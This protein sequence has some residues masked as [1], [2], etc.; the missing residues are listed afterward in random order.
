MYSFIT[1][2]TTVDEKEDGSVFAIQGPQGS[3]EVYEYE[4]LMVQIVRF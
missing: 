2:I 4:H 3:L 1:H